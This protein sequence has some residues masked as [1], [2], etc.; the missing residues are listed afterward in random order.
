V[1]YLYIIRGVAGG[2]GLGQ[3]VKVDKIVKK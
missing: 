2:A 1:E 3:R